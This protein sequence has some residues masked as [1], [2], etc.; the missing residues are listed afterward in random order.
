MIDDAV[1]LVLS[2]SF[3]EPVYSPEVFQRRVILRK[4]CLIHVIGRPG[5][6]VRNRTAD[7]SPHMWLSVA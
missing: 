6:G 1:P 2:G 4:R 3:I 7:L 5:T